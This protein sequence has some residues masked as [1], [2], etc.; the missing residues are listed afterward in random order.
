MGLV[1]QGNWQGGHDHQQQEN[2][3]REARLEN[4]LSIM[5]YLVAGELILE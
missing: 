3:Y 5:R 1:N 2:D 4:C